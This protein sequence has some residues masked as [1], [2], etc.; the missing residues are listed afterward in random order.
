MERTPIKFA[1]D[2]LKR[3]KENLDFSKEGKTATEC[4]ISILHQ[5]M[6]Y[7]KDALI[8]FAWTFYESMQIEIEEG[9]DRD[10]VDIS[11]V[12]DFY[13]E[14]FEISSHGVSYEHLQSLGQGRSKN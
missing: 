9:V 7:E 4:C 2:S 3:F 12:K 1:I 6:G 10:V 11:T 13:A 8:K 5:H 14:V